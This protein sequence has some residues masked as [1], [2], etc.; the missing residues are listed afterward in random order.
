MIK[1]EDTGR[2]AMNLKKICF[3]CM[4]EKE[5]ETGKCPYCGFDLNT[6]EYN[7]RW[8]R[9]GHILDGKY[10]LGKVI[11]EGG[12]GITYIGWDLNMEVR[13]A[14]KEYFPI[15]LASREVRGTNQYTLVTLTGDKKESYEHGMEKF[16][17]E[18]KSLAKF[19]H[20]EG[21]VAVKD[22]FFENETAY[23]VME[24]VDGMTLRDYLRK[25]GGY[26]S[27]EETLHI[28][29]PVIRSL[30][31]VHRENIIHRDISPDNIMIT[32]SG[33]SKLIDF[34]AARMSCKD[35][36]H[37]F[38]I[39][40]KHGYA[41][42][43]QYQTKGYQGPWTDVYAVC[44][45]IY[46]AITGQLPPNAMDR[47]NQDELKTFE[48]AGSHVPSGM[49][50]VIIRKGMALR[51][52]N[53]YQSME[54]LYNALCLLKEQPKE[55]TSKKEKK[56][57]NNTKTRRLIAGI[58]ISVLLGIGG[59]LFGMN[60]TGKDSREPETNLTEYSSEA[61]TV[62]QT[63][64]QTEIQ[65]ETEWQTE[66]EQQQEPDYSDIA[67]WYYITSRY[68]KGIAV[69][70]QPN[71]ESELLTR[72]PYGTEFY[73]EAVCDNWGYTTVNGS[74]GW[75]ELSYADH[76]SNK[77]ESTDEM[78]ETGWY[79]IVSTYS[80]GIAVR[81]EPSGESELLTR[82]PYGTRFYVETTDGNWGYT[83]VNGATGWIEL[84]YAAKVP[85]DMIAVG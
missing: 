56:P 62:Q 2:R 16:A 52:E 26:L 84:T 67:N 85:D 66:T 76:L 74:T 45:T 80:K 22:F 33:E 53:R 43:E 30:E 44:A 72:I 14:I 31:T 4:R 35:Q 75:I 55:E 46:R 49:T 19:Y 3:G 25:K 32:R 39:I 41:P 13:V 57:V 73:V 78:M 60:G 28:F 6:Y 63:E 64:V 12:F 70:S 50:D 83:T 17:A 10:L 23:M 58:S 27:V 42:P 37:T 34:G 38:T 82:I 20:L 5:Q 77:D 7:N 51:V 47:L 68:E 8:L 18:A 9:L 21:I 71:G 40:L 1:S 69:R 29:Q 59:I 79:D 15:G 61:E 54:E 48:E 36:N 81:S 65:A 24:Y 11:G